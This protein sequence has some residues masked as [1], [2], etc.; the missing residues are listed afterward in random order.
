MI[1]H[2]NLWQALIKELESGRFVA[3]SITD[4]VC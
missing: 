1:I 3:I 4:N 2:T